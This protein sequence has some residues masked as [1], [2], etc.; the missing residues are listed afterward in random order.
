[1]DDDEPA[2]FPLQGYA[3]VRAGSPPGR[4]GSRPSA[5]S[6]SSPSSSSGGGAAPSSPPYNYHP[7]RVVDLRL[8]PPRAATHLPSCADTAASSHAGGGAAAFGGRPAYLPTYAALARTNTH[9]SDPRVRAPIQLFR[10]QVCRWM[11]PDN[12][13]DE[14]RLLSLQRLRAVNHVPRHVLQLFRRMAMEPLQD[15]NQLITLLG[16]ASPYRHLFTEFDLVFYPLQLAIHDAHDLQAN[17]GH[18]NPNVTLA[19]MYLDAIYLLVENPR[20]TAEA[21]E[22]NVRAHGVTRQHPDAGPT[23]KRPRTG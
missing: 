2:S 1:M 23:G 19:T 17:N 16:L 21:F 4:G 22:R 6:S 5:S 14:Q 12:H 10:S 3:E 18:F 9:P 15:Y 13:Q 20:G 7:Q 11:T 8:E